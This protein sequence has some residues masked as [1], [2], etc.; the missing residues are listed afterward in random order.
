MRTLP[1]IAFVAALML[2]PG[3]C[4]RAQKK[5]D[6]PGDTVVFPRHTAFETSQAGSYLMATQTMALEGKQ[7][8]LLFDQ[9]TGALV[10]VVYHPENIHLIP[11]AEATTTVSFDLDGKPIATITDLPLKEYRKGNSSLVL[12]FASNEWRLVETY[13]LTGPTAWKRSAAITYLGKTEVKIRGIRFWMPKLCIGKASYT[14]L[15][16]PGNFHPRSFPLTKLRAG[17]WISGWPC[18]LLHNPLQRLSFLAMAHNES[19]DTGILTQTDPGK[20]A[21][22]LDAHVQAR[23]RPG[24]TESVGDAHYMVVSGERT[25]ALQTFRDWYARVGIRPPKDSP[26]WAKRA[27]LYSAHPGGVTHFWFKGVGGFR[28]FERQ[29]PLLAR[30]G[31][32]ALWLLPIYSN[33][34]SPYAPIDYFKLDPNLGTPEEC[35]A[36]VKEAHRLGIRVLFD[37]IPHG[38]RAE[39]PLLKEH[40]EFVSRDEKGELL[41][42]WGCLSTDY[43]NPNFQKWFAGMAEW[44][45]KTYDIDG[46]RVDC[47]GGGPPNWD[48][49]APY[50][51]SFSGLGGSLG[52]LRAVR[53]QMKAVKPGTLLF[54]EV[55]GDPIQFKN[56]DWV[57][58]YPLFVAMRAY[59]SFA[60]PG[61]WVRLIAEWLETQK[62]VY[63]RGATLVRFTENHDTGRSSR[64]FGDDLME[65]MFALCAFAPGVPMIYQEQ[66]IGHSEGFARILKARRALP[67]LCMDD[68][69]YTL[70]RSSSP[71]V[72]C[73]YYERGGKSALALISFSPE[74]VTTQVSLP[75]GKVR[76]KEMQDVL[77]G[78]R[79]SWQSH[80]ASPVQV[81]LKPF[82]WRAFRL[83][84]LFLQ[85]LKNPSWGRLRRQPSCGRPATGPSSRHFRPEGGWPKAQE[86]GFSKPGSPG[87]TFPSKVSIFNPQNEPVVLQH[88]NGKG[89]TVFPHARRWFAHTTSGLVGDIYF[90]R[91]FDPQTPQGFDILWDSRTAPLH[92]TTGLCGI[93]DGQRWLLF[94]S[95]SSK[96][97][98]AFSESPEGMQVSV[99]GASEARS[100]REMGI[101]AAAS[102]ASWK[103]I[104][105]YCREHDGWFKPSISGQIRLGIASNQFLVENSHF[106][107]VLDG[108]SGGRLK[109]LFLAGSDSPLVALSDLY[110]DWGFYERGRYVGMSLEVASYPSWEWQEDGSLKLSFEG[111]LRDTG[112]NTVNTG[113]PQPATRYR[114]TYHCDPFASLEVELAVTPAADRRG[115]SAFLGHRMALPGMWDWS[116]LTTGESLSGTARPSG[117]RLWQSRQEKQIP[118][119]VEGR[120]PSGWVRLQAIEGSRLQNAFLLAADEGLA[121]YFAFLDGEPTDW[122][123]GEWRVLRYRIEVGR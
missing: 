119:L 91:H 44:Y 9:T 94:R 86:T 95:N 34:N 111:S 39:G 22:M 120:G 102:R 8:S 1:Y 71:E 48:E 88:R 121:P 106:R 4:A 21:P 109:A 55:F 69:S 20:A 74:A 36:L 47:A 53:Q 54:Q 5:P 32:T 110:S 57:Y 75:S 103:S 77:S 114:L 62:Y 51:A 117:D 66:E 45:V 89:Y 116:I 78:E 81:H 64:L 50:R 105:R 29:L 108:T 40:P 84:T 14:F 80:A 12:I 2:L 87:Y 112:W 13:A 42:W 6:I 38:P 19:E 67:A 26:R 79:L 3:I 27:V 52:L 83:R 23:M 63:P 17:G 90:R 68:A 122:K 96:R 10:D 33:P 76:G 113:V 35:R 25:Q 92:P 100:W 98:L 43:A 70:A 24:H 49:K 41:Y 85:A 58:D 37:L 28:S 11:S 16:F 115:V 104:E 30:L 15:E 93:H 82:G 18:F 61:E 65:A 7:I 60:R 123:A 59:K 118:A 46:W 56:G 99:E 107:A 73:I 72:L 101:E 31:A 97:H